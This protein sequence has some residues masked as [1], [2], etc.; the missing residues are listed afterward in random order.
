MFIF[1]V[2]QS[3]HLERGDVSTG[4]DGVHTGVRRVRG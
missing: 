1:S 3:Y 4:V 2:A